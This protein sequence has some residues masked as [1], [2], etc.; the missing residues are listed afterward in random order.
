MKSPAF[1][2][3]QAKARGRKVYD[4]YCGC[5]VC[6]N[7][8]DEVEEKFKYEEIVEYFKEVPKDAK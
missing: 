7:L 3:G 4:M 1:N 5:C 8:K 6:Y 2:A